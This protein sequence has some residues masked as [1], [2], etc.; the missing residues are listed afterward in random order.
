[1]YMLG[2]ALVLTL[3]KYLEIGPVANWS[4]WW[5]LAPYGLTAAWW[6]WA[7][8][9]GYTKRKEVEKIERRK[10]ARVNKHKEAMGMG[11]RRPR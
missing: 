2:L 8:A 7:D 3:L 1:M 5:V 11:S 10:Q 6:A 4:W 9:S